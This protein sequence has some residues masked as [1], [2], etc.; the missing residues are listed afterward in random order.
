MWQVGSG[1]LR[2]I[3]TRKIALMFS[4]LRQKLRL[5]LQ[6]H[7]WYWRLK[8]LRKSLKFQRIRMVVNSGSRLSAAFSVVAALLALLKTSLNSTVPGTAIAITLGMASGLPTESIPN[9]LSVLLGRISSESVAAH[10]T[11]LAVVLTVAGL[12]LTLYYTNFNTV[13]GTLYGEYPESV[14]RLLIDEPQNRAALLALTN[15]IVFTLVT[16][17]FGAG[18]GIRVNVSLLGVVVGGA[19]IVPIFAFITRRTLFFFDPT[20]LANSA[21][22]NLAKEISQ[23]TADSRFASHTAVQQHRATIANSELAKLQALSRIAAEKTTFRRDSLCNLL[24]VVFSFLPEYQRLK[25]SIPT[26]SKWYRETVR[27]K[28]WY[29]AGTTDLQ[30]ALNSALGLMPEAVQDRDWLEESIVRMLEQCFER[31]LSEHDWP[32]ASRILRAS[33]LMFEA[34]AAGYQL[35]I[36]SK[37]FRSLCAS[38]EQHGGLSDNVLGKEDQLYRLQVTAELNMLAKQILLSFFN[39]LRTLDL[40]SYMKRVKSVDWKIEDDIYAKEFPPFTL[41]Q[42]EYLRDRLRIEF[43]A[44]G[45]IVSPEWYIRQLALLPIAETLDSQLAELLQLGR[46]FYVDRPE[47]LANSGMQLAAVMTTLDGLEYFHKL[48]FHAV[49]I[50]ERMEIVEQNR[51]LEAIACPKI[52][53]ETVE[54]KIGKSE[55]QLNLNLAKFVPFF[56]RDDYEQS[57]EIPDLQGHV[58]TVLANSYFQGLMSKDVE[59]CTHVFRSYLVGSICVRQSIGEKCSGLEYPANLAYAAEPTTEAFAL[60]GF[61]F[62]LSEYHQ[63]PELWESCVGVWRKL[64]VDS[65]TKAKVAAEVLLIDHA[66]QLPLLTGRSVLRTDW[67]QKF[68]RLVAQLPSKC[69]KKDADPIWHEARV[70]NH[71]SLCIRAIVSCDIPVLSIRYDPQNIFLDVFLKKEIALDRSNAWRMPDVNESMQR[72]RELEERHGFVYEPIGDTENANRS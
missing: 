25:R 5:W 43:D 28:D 8:R 36:A 19:S 51:V 49:A 37:S 38:I 22:E 14:R 24:T 72:Q 69:L 50:Y 17:G 4:S 42:M 47:R 29:L 57:E 46:R 18:L 35:Q 6:D 53:R 2:P 10:D 1:W 20:Y 66:N 31:T 52:D 68:T 67:G 62:L 16:L 70:R 40:T 65:D 13:I 61:A 34:L 64:L 26:T 33:R 9:L 55:R 63:E 21:I 32:V 71:P 59:L 15:F 7:R 27:H 39:E 30:V 45:D 12:F 44:D 48:R 3:S 56:T 41:S 11:L 54:T 23:A 58:V 60:S